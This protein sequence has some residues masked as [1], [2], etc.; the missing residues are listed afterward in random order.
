MSLSLAAINF[1]LQL[2]WYDE[3]ILPCIS[4]DFF[5]CGSSLAGKMTSHLMQTCAS[6]P[7]S[8]EGIRRM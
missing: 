2:D 3:H 7:R 8:S 4:P 5:G 1:S 6:L